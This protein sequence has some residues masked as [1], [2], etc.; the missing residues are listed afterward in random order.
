M[1]DTVQTLPTNIYES[2]WPQGWSDRRTL[3][4]LL[5]LALF[6]RGW[7]V[8]ATE[9]P[10]RD[11]IGFIRYALRFEHEDWREIIQSSHQHPG[12]PV[13]VL[14]MS[15]PV[16][17]WYGGI[18]CYSMQVSAQ[19]VSSLAGWLLV[20]PMYY[21]GK[22]VFSRGVGF[23]S[24]LLFQ[25]LPE[26]GHVLSDAI[27]DPLYLLLTAT[28]LLFGMYAVAQHSPQRYALCGFFVGLAYLVRPEGVLV[29]A[30]T[31][32]VMLAV[33]L[34]PHWRCP[35]TR[36]VV[37]AASL[38]LAALVAGSPYFLVTGNITNKPNGS[39][40]LVQLPHVRGSAAEAGQTTTGSPL[41][42][43][44]LAVHI[45][46]EGS[47]AARAIRGGKAMCAEIAHSY[48][49]I[50]W[51]PAFLGLWWC[52]ER[53]RQVP[54]TWITLLLLMLHGSVVWWLTMKAGYVS[55]R[56]VLLLVLGTIY[57]AVAVVIQIPFRIQN[58]LCK[59]AHTADPR[60]Q[61]LP[62]GLEK[63]APVL[64]GPAA[65]ANW[66]P[67]P[68]RTSHLGTE[69][70]PL[71]LHA[72]SWS[73]L[74]LLLLT[75]A[76]LSRTLRPLHAHRQGHHLAGLWLAKHTLP[77]DVIH[78][79]HSWAHYYAGRVFLEHQPLV[80]PPG[81][82]PRVYYVVSR[83]SDRGD[84][85]HE[86]IYTEAGLVSQGGQVVYQWPEALPVQEARVLIYEMPH[87]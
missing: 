70:P 43:S 55:D 25:C 51:L 32:V 22:L 42:A 16:R 18:D 77:V 65:A 26:S 61:L 9:V 39:H 62:S 79:D 75:G 49:Y 50:G 83:T 10:A 12:Y 47:L 57:L 38:V 85:S 14:L 27:S 21:L 1:E 40:F 54:G 31:G 24:A 35:W 58:G 36:W 29:L 41:L 73:L 53:F 82:Q 5:L 33:Q 67:S 3:L 74:L 19:L 59:R 60:H 87:K 46:Q 76:G 68:D 66:E 78:D 69:H 48:Q 4:L 28:A 44:I 37:C 84:R 6:V 80:C 30:A 71:W 64:V 86:M 81:H 63:A 45:D 8:W 17:W 72:S 20:I 34:V 52:R 2:V 23:W 15:W 13:S 56:H 7:V 11:S